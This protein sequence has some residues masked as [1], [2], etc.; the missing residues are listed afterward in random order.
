MFVHTTLR[1]CEKVT[2]ID[3]NEKTPDWSECGTSDCDGELD[4]E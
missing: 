2:D 1:L 4:A 3:Y